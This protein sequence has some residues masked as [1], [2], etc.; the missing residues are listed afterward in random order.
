LANPALSS[1]LQ[2]AS[3]TAEMRMNSG[4]PAGQIARIASV[5]SSAKRIRFCGEPP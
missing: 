3:S 4:L 1:T 5:I 2:P